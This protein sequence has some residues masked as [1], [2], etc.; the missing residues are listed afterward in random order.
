MVCMPTHTQCVC[1]HLAGSTEGERLVLLSSQWEDGTGRALRS[2]HVT[3][4]F[5]HQGGGGRYSWVGGTAGWG[6]SGGVQG[7]SHPDD[8]VAHGKVLVEANQRIDGS[9]DSPNDLLSPSLSAPPPSVSVLSESWAE[10]CFAPV[11]WSRGLRAAGLIRILIT[12]EPHHAPPPLQSHRV[13]F[14]N[15]CCSSQKVDPWHAGPSSWNTFL[16]RGFYCSEG[17]NPVKE[18]RRT[19]FGN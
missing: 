6:V 5:P 7:V 4:H 2:A 19:C 3:K 10:T 1:W 18:Q 8:R 16:S 17:M 9:R 12:E 11:W 13:A 14:F 15:H